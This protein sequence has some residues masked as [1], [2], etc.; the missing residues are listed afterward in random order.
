MKHAKAIFSALLLVAAFTAAAYF[1]TRRPGPPAV[2]DETRW[3]MGTEVKIR[4]PC[5][6][7]ECRKIAA[8]AFA[9]AEE[10]DAKMARRRGSELFAIDERGEGKAGPGLV[11]V[12]AS[13]RKWAEASDG[14]FD[15]T[16]GALIDLWAVEKGP[17][18][19]P[20]RA[21]IDAALAGTGWK[22]FSVDNSSGAVLTGGTQ[23]D[24]GAI[25]KGYA[26]DRCAEK[27]KYQGYSDYIVDAGGDLAVGGTKMGAPWRIGLLDPETPGKMLAIYTAAPGAVVTSGDYERY[28]E[29][30]GVRYGHIFDP[31]TGL[32]AK[33]LASVTVWSGNAMDADALATAVFVLGPEKGLKLIAESPPAEVMLIDHEGRTRQS[34]GFDR[35]MRRVEEKP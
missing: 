22:K 30:E 1:A 8:T 33:S 28:F 6:G 15:P 24:L 21:E 35:V 26:A 2:Y 3:L 14:A 32:P 10:V 17:H 16:L 12:L 7:P 4:F 13:A 18:P 23:I 25:A 27:L 11:K 34:P 9:E 29:W 5:E 20:G 31:A 19:P